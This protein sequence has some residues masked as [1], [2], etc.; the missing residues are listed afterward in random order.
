MPRTLKAIHPED[1]YKLRHI[2][3]PQISPDGTWIAC[4]LSQP[5]QE[6]DRGL[7][8]IWLISSDGRRRLQ[9]TNRHHRDHSPRWSPDGERIAFVAP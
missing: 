1:V 9:L 4:I 6:K 7:S 8:D 5:E 3:D 2:S